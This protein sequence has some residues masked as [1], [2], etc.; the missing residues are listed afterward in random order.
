MFFETKNLSVFYDKVHVLFDVSI[1]VDEGEG[2]SLIGSHGAGKSTFINTISGILKAKSG[3]VIFKGKPLTNISSDD[4]VES[5]IVQVPEGRQV[6]PSMTVTENLEVGSL[7]KRARGRKTEMMK[8]V[9]EIFPELAR[10]GK[11]LAGTL[12]GG[13]Q[14]MLAVGRA[15]MSCP[16]LLMLD[17]PSLGLAPKIV[18]G[19]FEI[20]KEINHGGTSVLIVE[21]NVVQALNISTRAYVLENGTIVLEG[22]AKELL[23]DEKVKKAYLGI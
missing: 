6:F 17:E 9:K 10:C 2:I 22:T 7:V 16:L 3:E 15:L 23:Q 13:Q 4:I 18:A 8:K 21:Q 12:S 19:V 11:Q 20:V 14:Q 5:G 1:K